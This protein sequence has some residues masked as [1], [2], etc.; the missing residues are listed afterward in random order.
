MGRTTNPLFSVIRGHIGRPEA[1]D[2]P[3]TSNRSAKKHRK[4]IETRPTIDRGPRN[5]H[6]TIEKRSTVVRR[7]V[8]NKPK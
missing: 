5:E 2:Q 4:T 1:R 3:I 8:R 7:Q 6:L